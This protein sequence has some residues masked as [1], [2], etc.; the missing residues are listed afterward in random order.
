MRPYKFHPAAEEEFNRSI[1][2]YNQKQAGIG[3]DFARNVRECISRIRHNPLSGYVSEHGTRTQLVAAYPYKLVFGEY[4]GRIWIIAV[5]HT[6][7]HPRY[8]HR[9]MR[10]IGH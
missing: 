5:A 6:S 7:R 8:W 10:D 3:N 9:R 2:W 1:D 4:G